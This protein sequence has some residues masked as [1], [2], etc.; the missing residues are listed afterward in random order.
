MTKFDKIAKPTPALKEEFYECLKMKPEE[1]KGK[2]LRALIKRAT[3]LSDKERYK[4]R[5]LLVRENLTKA[6]MAHLRR[7]LPTDVFNKHFPRKKD[8]EEHYKT[9]FLAGR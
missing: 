5:N 2:Y 3:Q 4:F 7:I 9:N 6:E 1:I 8:V